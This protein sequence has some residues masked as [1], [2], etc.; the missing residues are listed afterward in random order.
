MPQNA[1]TLARCLPAWTWCLREGTPS[2]VKENRVKSAAWG[3][4]TE[5]LNLGQTNPPR[6]GLA[7]SWRA[8]RSLIGIKLFMPT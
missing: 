8:Y 1:S 5:L 2:R 6:L 4:W 7:A 3:V